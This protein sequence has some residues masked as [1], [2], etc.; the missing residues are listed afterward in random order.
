MSY[1]KVL[2]ML[3]TAILLGLLLAISAHAAC[4]VYIMPDGRMV[5]MCCSPDGLMCQMM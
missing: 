2:L 5:T 4:T 3:L 1:A